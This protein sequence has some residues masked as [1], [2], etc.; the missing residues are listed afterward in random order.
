M[1]IVVIPV[2]PY[3]QNCSLIICEETKQAAIVDP[4]GEADRIL[5]AVNNHKVNV[6]KIILTH[7]HLDHVGGTEVLAERLNIPIVGPEK[8]DAFW[9]NQL[10]AQSTMFN[11]PN[12]R[13][14]LPTQWLQE[15]D[16]VE[17]GNIKLNILHIPGHT[18]GHV[19]LFDAV[20][21]QIIVGDILFNG[22]IGRSDFPRGNHSQL[23]SGIKQKLLTLPQDT[24]VFP[25]HGP[26]TTIAH[27][28]ATN[29]YLR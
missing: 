8:E 9:L 1:K 7:G 24:V 29:P 4:G 12:T 19:A 28:K 17:V 16:V 27:E 23:I 14:F 18:P 26:T 10:E 3:Q 25:G 20:S 2:T 11:F 5:S 6:D 15:G 22:A 13:S 21:K